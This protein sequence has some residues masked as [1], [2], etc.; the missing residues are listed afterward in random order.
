MDRGDGSQIRF[1][2]E[3][4]LQDLEFNG[5]AAAMLRDGQLAFGGIRGLNLI[6]P[7]R[8]LGHNDR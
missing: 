6:D 7:A 5:H 4:G 2:M 8:D 3:A 1:G